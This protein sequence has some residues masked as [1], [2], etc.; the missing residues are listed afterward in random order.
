MQ[1]KINL[2][3]EITLAILGGVA[4]L[5]IV[6]LINGPLTEAKLR[7]IVRE[8]TTSLTRLPASE[9]K[10]MVFQD[11]EGKER[12]LSDFAG[13]PV[14]MNLWA[15]WCAPCIHEMPVL[16]ALQTRYKD[17]LHVIAISTDA[18]GFADIDAFLAAHPVDH[19]PFYHDPGMKLSSYLKIRGLP[20]TF[21]LNAQG[22]TVAKLERGIEENDQE[23]E[24]LVKNLVETAPQEIPK[25]GTK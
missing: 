7:R 19:P 22:Q 16:A 4:M 3:K 21:I 23:L 15:S 14:I 5:F 2:K 11:R 8:E 6:W 13:K 18:G 25:A 10:S 17:K 1:P 24:E 9:E 12:S 20:T